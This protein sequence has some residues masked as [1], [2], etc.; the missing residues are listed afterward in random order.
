MAV[1][2]LIPPGKVSLRCQDL[3]KKS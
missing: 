2:C 3:E 1:L